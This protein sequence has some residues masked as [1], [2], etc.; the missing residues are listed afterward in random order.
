MEYCP[1]CGKELSDNH[2]FCTHC[3]KTVSQLQPTVKPLIGGFLL[4]SAGIIGYIIAIIV[5]IQE[6]GSPHPNK[7]EY[8][9]PFMIIAI[10]KVVGPTFGIMSGYYSLK[11]KKF[12]FVITTIPF[13]IITA[14]IDYFTIRITF[15]SIIIFILGIFSFI[16]ISTSKNEFV[17]LP[18]SDL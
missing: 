8:V 18:D 9:I 16:F 1:I 15:D 6:N 14:F 12:R 11:R 7:L 13:I 10:I 4:L 3:G 17:N 2:N 5:M